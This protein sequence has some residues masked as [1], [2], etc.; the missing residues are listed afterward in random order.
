MEIYGERCYLKIS[1][2]AV[3][4]GIIGRITL[5]YPMCDMLRYSSGDLYKMAGKK[6]IE[7]LRL[8]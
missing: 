4:P 2:T 6:D 8:L 7:G 1:L 5:N 3:N